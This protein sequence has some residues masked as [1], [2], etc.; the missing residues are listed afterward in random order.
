MLK[1][2]SVKNLVPCF[3]FMI[4]ILFPACGGGGGG[5]STG[6]SSS[7]GTSSSQQASSVNMGSYYYTEQAGDTFTFNKNIV[8]SA[9]DQSAETDITR[10]SSF[11]LI[12]EIPVAYDY[13]GD[14][15]GPYLLKT[16]DEDG[17]T[18]S[19]TYYT[20]DGTKII[21]DDLETYTSIDGDNTYTG[22]DQSAIMT[23]DD[24][25]HVG[26]AEQLFYSTTAAPVG[27]R[28]IDMTIE[29]LDIV[30]VTVPA[31]T[32]EAVK[33]ETASSV[34]ETINGISETTE[35]AGYVWYGEHVGMVKSE[36]TYTQTVSDIEITTTIT[37]TLKDVEFAAASETY[38]EE[39]IDLPQWYLSDIITG[40]T[41]SDFLERVD[42]YLPVSYIL[43]SSHSLSDG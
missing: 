16:I 38:A 6:S 32:C 28:T 21:D 22:D 18:I 27:T 8:L 14:L 9:A 25:Y 2:G 30:S 26:S 41:F 7:S 39:N 43:D 35:I 34:T 4:F 42:G 40:A 20:Q 19:V 37:T 10:T 1:G 24:E 23:F 12:D 5:G 31:G 29:A 13:S 3:L 11:T 17:E 33:I 15:S 36:F